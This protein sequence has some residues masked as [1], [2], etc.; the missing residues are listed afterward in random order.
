MPRAFVEL[1][2]GITKDV[3]IPHPKL[4]Q[5]VWRGWY[6]T[7]AQR[8][9]GLPSWRDVQGTDEVPNRYYTSWV[10]ITSEKLEIIIQRSQRAPIDPTPYRITIDRKA[11]SFG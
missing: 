10:T 4:I 6:K 5:E 2:G 8:V 9:V 3:Q 7:V 11:R 1:P